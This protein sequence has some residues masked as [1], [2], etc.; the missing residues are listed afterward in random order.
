MIN[1]WPGWTY[2]K[3]NLS[4]ILTSDNDNGNGNGNAALDL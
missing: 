1:Y 4:Q 2:I 3:H